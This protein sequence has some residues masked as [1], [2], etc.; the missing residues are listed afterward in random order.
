MTETLVLA[1]NIK[2]IRKKNHQTQ[3]EFAFN[4]GLSEDEIYNIEH[5]NTDPK[6]STLQNIAAYIG[7][8]VSEL[9]MPHAYNCVGKLSSIQQKAMSS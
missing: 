1:D 2:Q 4:C 9:L 5:C 3:A 7:I 8:T 6:L